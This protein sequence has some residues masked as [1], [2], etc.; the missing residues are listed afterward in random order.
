MQSTETKDSFLFCYPGECEHLPVRPYHGLGPVEAL[1]PCALDS[2]TF[3]I[4]LFDDP[5][6]FQLRN[7]P[8]EKG[9]ACLKSHEPSLGWPVQRA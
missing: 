5:L 2:L 4:A 1:P 8:R 6:I 7:E 3:T 9:V